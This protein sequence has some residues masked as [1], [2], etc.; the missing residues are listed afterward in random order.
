MAFLTERGNSSKYPRA[1]L[2]LENAFA[3][4]GGICRDSAESNAFQEPSFFAAST[5]VSPAGVINPALSSFS[6]RSLLSFDQ[7][8]F[9]FREVNHS[10]DRSSSSLPGLLSIQPKQRASSTASA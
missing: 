1:V 2:F 8:V 5:F 6:T 9:D 7:P 4:S 3:R 10:M